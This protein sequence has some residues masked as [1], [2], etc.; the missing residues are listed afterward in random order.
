MINTY[1]L[2]TNEQKKSPYYTFVESK[3]PKCQTRSEVII[4]KE[5]DLNR[6]CSGENRLNAQ[7][8]IMEQILACKE[9]FVLLWDASYVPCRPV[10][11]FTELGIP[12]Q[13]ICNELTVY[14]GVPEGLLPEVHKEITYSF[15][16]GHLLVK[17][18]YLREMVDAIEQESGLAWENAILKSVKSEHGLSGGFDFFEMYGTYILQKYPEAYV[19]REWSV[20]RQGADLLDPEEMTDALLTWLGRQYDA[21]SFEVGHSVRED[22]HGLITDPTYQARLTPKQLIQAIQGEYKDNTA[23]IGMEEGLLSAAD[24]MALYRQKNREAEW[25]QY[26]RIGDERIET[27]PQQAWLSWQHAAFLCDDDVE[28]KRICVKMQTLDIRVPPAAIVIVSYNSK[29]M[30]QECIESIRRYSGK[31]E[32]SIIVIDNASTDGVRDYLRLQKD[33]RLQLND[34]NVGFPVACN[35]GISLAATGEDILFLNNDTRMTH[36]ALYWLRMG[37]YETADTGAVGAVSNYAGTGQMLELLLATAENYEAYGRIKNIALAEPYDEAKIL[38]GFAMLVR[39][40]FID[41]FGGMDEAFTPGYYEDTDLSLRLRQQGYK[42]RICKNSFIYHAG[43]LN[44]KKRPDL[45]EINDR[46]LLYLAQKWE[47]D[48][49]N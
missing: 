4:V 31:E 27:N 24:V 19:Y 1:L 33:I 38:C 35:Q 44:F 17:T 48:F 14:D 49:M 15:R 36:N 20:L 13:N 5:E 6:W 41:Q 47:T 46:N 3:I 8:N 12:I 21:V 16:T 37:L 26:E 7:L 2:A 42:L 25:C 11:L 23:V 40:K 34:E 9:A 43:G 39:R 28:K 30:M 32:Y 18:E 10:S 29:P 45:E 22:N